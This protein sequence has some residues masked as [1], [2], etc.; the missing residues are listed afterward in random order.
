[1]TLGFF[2]TLPKVGYIN[3]GNNATWIAMNYGAITNRQVGKMKQT[4]S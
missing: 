4:Y 2:G 1:M 3:Y